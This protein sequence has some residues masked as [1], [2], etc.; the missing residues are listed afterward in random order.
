MS[1]WVVKNQH[2]DTAFCVADDAAEALHKA[3]DVLSR[4]SRG[5]VEIYLL[6]GDPLI[7]TFTPGTYK[8]EGTVA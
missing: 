7:A 2:G 3:G 1:K 8:I 4:G 5:P 6:T